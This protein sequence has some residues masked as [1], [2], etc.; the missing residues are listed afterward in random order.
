LTKGVERLSETYRLPKGANDTV[1]LKFQL[2]PFR[3]VGDGSLRETLPENPPKF[4]CGVIRLFLDTAARAEL[5]QKAILEINQ[6]AT[7]ALDQ[8]ANNP[9]VRFF[10]N[11]T[12]RL[13]IIR[14]VE[15]HKN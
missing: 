6:F 1:V 7:H 3:F 8:T 15:S 9:T 5:H 11:H 12:Q 4:S 14:C 13:E 10:T 2:Q